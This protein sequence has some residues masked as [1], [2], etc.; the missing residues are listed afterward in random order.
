MKRNADKEDPTIGSHWPVIVKTPEGPVD[1]YWI[2]NTVLTIGKRE[3]IHVRLVLANET[4]VLR[5]EP[6]GRIKDA[7]STFQTE[8]VEMQDEKGATSKAPYSRPPSPLMYIREFNPEIHRPFAF[9]VPKL[10]MDDAI[11]DYVGHIVGILSSRVSVQKRGVPFGEVLLD[12]N[13]LMQCLGYCHDRRTL[14]EAEVATRRINDAVNEKKVLLVSGRLSEK[15]AKAGRAHATVTDLSDKAKIQ[16]A[17]RR[18]VKQG[19]TH[20]GA[21][22]EIAKHCPAMNNKDNLLGLKYRYHISPDAVKR[23]AGVKK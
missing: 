12:N 22:K 8:M 4:L 17:F 20:H 3:E 11:T 2:H 14:E 7:D 16:K 18:Y 23:I 6:D 5:C 19:Y 21:A 10:R 15:K 13:L 9:N 1:V